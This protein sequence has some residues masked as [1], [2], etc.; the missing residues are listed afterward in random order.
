MSE[1]PNM[2]NVVNLLKIWAQKVYDTERSHRFDGTCFPLAKHCNYEFILAGLDVQNRTKIV[3][4]PLK[5]FQ[6]TGP[7]Y[8][9]I[10]KRVYRNGTQLKFTQTLRNKS[11]RGSSIVTI[12]RTNGVS[13]GD[14]ANICASLE[15]GREHSTLRETVGGNIPLR[16]MEE[17]TLEREGAEH[18]TTQTAT[19]RPGEVVRAQV[20]IGETQYAAEFQVET[21]VKG[22]VL[23]KVTNKEGTLLGQYSEDF[24]NIV[25]KHTRPDPNGTYHYHHAHRS[26]RFVTKG[27]IDGR[28]SGDHKIEV[29]PI[30]KYY[31][32][33]K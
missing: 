10:H 25:K 12:R 20:L 31:A 30:G 26:V 32:G 11:R 15:V 16:G 21:F 4:N 33:R 22:I 8:Q 23:V 18:E 24:Y 5:G 29:N 7:T 28:F 19:I 3:E 2:T 13:F 27:H 17:I 1:K 14:D 9:E 6:A